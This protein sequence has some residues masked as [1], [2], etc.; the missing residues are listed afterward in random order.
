MSEPLNIQ[1]QIALAASLAE[2][3]FREFKSASEGAPGKKTKR[4][5]RSISKDISE[6]LVA[7][8]NA[9]GG[10]LLVGVE[11]DGIVSGISNFTE[12]EIQLLKGAPLT[13]VHPDTPLQ[14]VLVREALIGDAKV[15]YFRVPKGTRF[16]HLTADG[17]CLKRNDP[18]TIPVAAE[19]IQFNRREV[20][21]RE[22]DRE[23]IDGASVADLDHDLL[24]AVAD[25]ISPGISLDKCLQYL[26]LAEYDGISGLR[27]R[28]AALLLFAKHPDRWHPRVQIRILKVTGTALG[29]GAA[30]NI[31]TDNT[32]RTNILRLIDETWE[33]LRPY[34]VATRFQEDARFRTTYIYPELA[35]REA[36]VNAIAHRDYSEEGRG[37]EI[38]IF[39]DRIE[40]KN[41]GGLLSSISIEDIK[42]L[43]G[44][45]QSRNSYVARTLR[46]VGLM[47]ELGEG[48]RRIFEVMR[49]GELA[50]PD[51]TNDASTFI[52]TLHHRPMYARDEVLWLDQYEAFHLT[53]EEKAAIL[54]GRKGE[55]IAP[56]HII[57]RLGIVDIEHYRQVVASLQK[58]GILE[59]VVD[60]A[61]LKNMRRKVAARDV[62]RFKV[63]DA[64]EA[65]AKPIA[66]PRSR[67]AET[68]NEES[69]LPQEI[70]GGHSQA[71]YLGNIPPNTTQRDLIAA[72]AAIGRP[73]SVIIPQTNGLS[74]GYAFIEFDKIEQTRDALKAEIS[75]GGRKLLIRPKLPWR[76]KGH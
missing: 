25:Q 18:E 66:K 1:E 57:R 37:I 72:F 60:R 41:P 20:A 47:R 65:F 14:S 7:F 69:R 6:A 67:R 29:T 64:R 2:G 4:S 75:L 61:A 26:N 49:S 56:N 74:R 10:E 33:S 50:P 35:C 48:M 21:S 63:R 42:A 11:D 23:F 28:R 9:D 68:V 52:L 45:H 54:I 13:H 27:L 71:L 51:I 24:R 22:Y 36:L 31:A 55:L 62:P 17:R 32:V 73:A 70:G 46:E 3:Q 34:L 5:T 53:P 43:T 40:I 16:I 8:A 58:K 15:L 30:Y 19:Q 39:D 59:T 12:E 76:H 44:V 38:Y